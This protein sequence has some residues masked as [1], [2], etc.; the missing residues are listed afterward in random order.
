MITRILEIQNAGSFLNISRGHLIISRDQQKV[1]SIP[2]ADIGILL[3]SNRACSLSVAVLTALA[4]HG[5][6]VVFCNDN[7]TPAGVFIPSQ[8][9]R[10]YAE[11]LELQIKASVPL[12]RRI[13]TKIVESK[14]K[15]QIA[16]LDTLNIDSTSLKLLVAKIQSGDSTNIEAQAAQRYWPLLMGENFRRKRLA[17]DAN[18]LLNYG[19][20]VLRA[21]MIRS[22]VAAGLNMALPLH[23]SA[24]ENLAALA[25]DLMEP[26]RPL[27]D[28]IVKRLVNFNLDYLCPEVKKEITSCLTI[29]IYRDKEVSTL[30]IIMHDLSLSL[31]ESFKSKKAGLSFL[32]LRSTFKELFSNHLSL[33]NENF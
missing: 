7:F 6:Q 8:S 27:I 28:L 30:P 16:V 11:R 20:T 24:K 3:I 9:S 4:E 12:K 1:G 18:I 29:D 15:N 13:W 17:S 2:I 22:I 14:V 32:D 25:D 23:H 10:A 31:I 26:F 21:A 19:Y 33:S 5:A